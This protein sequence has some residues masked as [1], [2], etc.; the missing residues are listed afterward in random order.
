M[1]IFRRMEYK[2]L[3]EV[4]VIENSSFSIPWTRQDFEESL[5]KEHAI[6]MV[7]ENDGEIIGYC[8]LWIV[9]DE[10]QINNV[11]VKHNYRGQSIG[12]GL[13]NAMMEEGNRL[14]INAYTLEVRVSNAPAIAL[15]TKV[16]FESAGIRKNYYSAPKEDAMIMWK[17]NK[18]NDNLIT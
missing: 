5:K 7:V 16:G 6:Y 18:V 8:G 14:G 12:T 15:Y 11:A 3:D 9:I 10:G 17:Y 2:D 13:L 4:V 1:L